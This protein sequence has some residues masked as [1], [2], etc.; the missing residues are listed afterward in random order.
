METRG[1]AWRP[2][3]QMSGM[4][5]RDRMP[6]LGSRCSPTTTGLGVSLRTESCSGKRLPRKLFL[7]IRPILTG[8]ELADWEYKAGCQNGRGPNWWLSVLTLNQA[9][10]GALK[11]SR[12]LLSPFHDCSCIKETTCFPQALACFG[13]RTLRHVRLARSTRT[14]RG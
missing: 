8:P 2:H 11:H 5:S 9:E 7:N 4:E 6:L 3:F 14:S 1:K 12:S 13:L 10:Q